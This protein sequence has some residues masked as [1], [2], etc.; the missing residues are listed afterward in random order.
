MERKIDRKRCFLVLTVFMVMSLAL[1][2]QTTEANGGGSDDGVSIST[3]KDTQVIKL[4]DKNILFRANVDIPNDYPEL[5]SYI[6]RKMF[7][8]DNR[9]LEQGYVDYMAKHDVVKDPQKA[10]KLVRGIHDFQFLE[11]VATGYVPD[12][13]LSYDALLIDSV[14]EK[15][16]TL[17][18]GKIT[19]EVTYSNS[20]YRRE[21]HIIFDLQ[22]R[23]VMGYDDVFA[24]DDFLFSEKEKSLDWNFVLMPSDM[25]LYAAPENAELVRLPLGCLRNKITD[26][27]SRFIDWSNVVFVDDADVASGKGYLFMSDS[28]CKLY[29]G[30]LWWKN[31]MNISDGE[32]DV[33]LSGSKEQR[34]LGAEIRL[35]RDY[36]RFLA[37]KERGETIDEGEMFYDNS[38]CDIH[39]KGI[40]ENNIN[41]VMSRTVVSSK[42]HSSDVT[43]LIERD[44]KLVV[45]IVMS[46]GNRNRWYISFEEFMVSG[47]RE[48]ISKC[49]PG[50]YNKKS[51]RT[52][53]K[54]RL[55]RDEYGKGTFEFVDN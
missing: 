20:S 28:V 9:S 3:I 26:N 40:N 45:P 2:A 51:V 53:V 46:L 36:M 32:I 6:C 54:L 55:I 29:N 49:S 35:A 8:V 1:C 41:S 4:K 34:V 16:K 11:I 31:V 48:Y 5:Q 14:Y 47:F 12:R 27:F 44:G 7:G 13:Y 30:G 17:S 25:S 33:F 50:R 21:Y 24:V 10:S 37:K 23:K 43:L 38:A 42:T 18:I 19:D 52:V 39:V 15:T 22:N